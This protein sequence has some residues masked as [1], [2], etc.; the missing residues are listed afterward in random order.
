MNY[1]VEVYKLSNDFFNDYP[2]SEYPELL[3]KEGRP[4]NCLLIDTHIDYFICIPFR[5]NISPHNSDSYIFK[6]SNRSKHHNS[7]LDYQKMLI[8]KEARYLENNAIVD[9]DE[10]SETMSNIDKIVMGAEK[11]LNTYIAH[12]N[13]THILHQRDY[14]RHYK[15]STLPYFHDILNTPVIS[16]T[17]PL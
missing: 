11:Y 16:S 1:D 4:Y 15:F 3:T 14:D 13:K 2:I 8:I 12:V 10:Y 7:G 17:M 6:N 9:Q 5:T